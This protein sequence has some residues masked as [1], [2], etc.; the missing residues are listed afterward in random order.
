MEAGAAKEREKN[1]EALDAIKAE[2]ESNNID[3]I[4]DAIDVLFPEASDSV[5]SLSKSNTASSE[6]KE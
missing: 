2:Q 5:N 4:D 1:K 6:T 3:N